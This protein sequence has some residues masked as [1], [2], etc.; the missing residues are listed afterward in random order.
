MLR[1]P[2]RPSLTPS[3]SRGGFTLVEILV[4]A[5]VIGLLAAVAVPQFSGSKEKAYVAA[6]KAD[7]HTAAVYEEGYAA[8][9]RGQYF[10][11]VATDD[12]FVEGFRPSKGVTVTFIATNILGSQ[13][14]EWR[15]VARHPQTSNVCAISAAGIACTTDYEPAIGLIA[16]N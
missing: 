15:A 12:S 3:R 16:G 9:N 7:L 10:S 5:S 2:P 13:L 4:V 1:I 11:G 8:E 6:M 14:S